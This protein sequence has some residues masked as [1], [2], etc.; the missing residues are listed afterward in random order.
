MQTLEPGTLVGL[1][2]GAAEPSRGDTRRS[3]SR[4]RRRPPVP[5]ALAGAAV[6]VAALLPALYLAIRGSEAG[7][8]GIFEIATGD[9][10]VGLLLRSSLLAVAVTATAVAVGVPVAWITTRTDLPGRR[11]WVVLTA[12]PLAI[13]SFIGGYT[14]VAALGPKGLVQGWL[15]PLGVDRLPSLYGFRGAW[16]VLTLFTYPY[17][18]LTVRAALRRLDPSLEEAGRSLGRSEWETFF[19]VVVPQLRPAIAGG[20]LLV[21]LYTL[22]DFGAVSLLRFDSFTRAIFV[23]YQASFDRTPAAVLS[24]MLV[25]LTAVILASEIRTRSRAV[26]HP[27]HGGAGRERRQTNLGRWRW[28]FALGCG[29]LVAL[30]L[31]VPLGVAGYWLLRGLSEGETL[32]FTWEAAR[33]S[34]EASALGAGVAVMAAWP[35]AWLSVRYRGL[36]ASVVEGTSWVGHALP[37]VVIALSLVFFGARYAPAVYQTRTM[38]VFAYVVLFLPVAVGALRTSLLQLSPSLEEAARALGSGRVETWRR[39]VVPLVAPGMAAGFALV[40]LAAMKELPATLLLAP[41]GYS[42]LATEVW[43]A[44]NSVFFARAAAPAIT[45]VLLSSLPLAALV[46]RERD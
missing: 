2:E 3:G 34:V 17:V 13:P 31:G 19:G 21:A 30:G 33:H 18:M 20:A 1:P 22:S 5:L 38:L 32:G 15:E 44:A 6:A 10:A 23:Q 7:V 11:A 27:V 35:V 14:F 36:A 37:G 45:L 9:R 42:T 28:A 4:K 46:L 29:L 39:V 43:S 8:D 24:L 25:A 26:Y 41:T 16:L 40:F 12:L